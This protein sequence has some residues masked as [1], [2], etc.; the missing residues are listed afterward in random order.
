MM[1]MNV[2]PTRLMRYQTQGDYFFASGVL[3]FAIERSNFD[4]EAACL[5]HEIGEWALCQKAGIPIEVID[6]WDMN[7]PEL[8]DPGSH[9][10]APYHEQHMF[11]LELEKIFFDKLKGVN[12]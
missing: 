3:H 8:E 4:D 12:P 10:L 2:V 7:H 9:P 6:E 1:I 5:I 11:M